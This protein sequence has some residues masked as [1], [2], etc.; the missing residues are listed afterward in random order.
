MH[1]KSHGGRKPSL[2]PAYAELLLV[3][4]LS[5]WYVLKIIQLQETV[6]YVATAVSK[7]AKLAGL[8][9]KAVSFSIAF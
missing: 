1:K 2:I 3:K 4:T 9:W 5:S 7:A 6:L 8:L